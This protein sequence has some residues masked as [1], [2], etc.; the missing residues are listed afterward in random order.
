MFRDELDEKQRIREDARNL[1]LLE[2]AKELLLDED[3]GTELSQE[4]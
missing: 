1:R 4:E 3:G 2:C